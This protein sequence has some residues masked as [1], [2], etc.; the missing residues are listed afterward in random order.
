MT[1]Q[2]SLL[3]PPVAQVRK[4]CSIA[5]CERPVKARGW[6]RLHYDRWLRKGSPDPRPSPLE[7][8]QANYRVNPLTGCWEWSGGRDT[9]GYSQWGLDRRSAGAHR[10]AYEH[11]VGPIPDGL[12]IDHLCRNRACVNPAH[13][14]PVS[15]VEN[16]RRGVSP[17][18]LN[19]RKT[20]CG[21][22]HEF[23][24]ENTRVNRSGDRAC[25][26][27]GREASRRYRERVA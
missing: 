27:C 23:T 18:A 9:H 7:R 11:F 22:G 6:C 19:A 21:N 14:E 5:D 26:A 17:P 13:L 24:P 25:R 20:H 8:F 15:N 10:W 3:D 16:I 2:L 12:V 4:S 1:Q